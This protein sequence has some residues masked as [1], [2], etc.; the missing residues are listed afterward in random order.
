MPNV[1]LTEPMDY[2]QFTHAMGAAHLLLTDSGGVQEEAPSLGKP[3]LVMRDTTE[4]PEAVQAGTVRLVGTDEE[5]VAKRLDALLVDEDAYREM[6]MAHNPY[7]DG[8]AAARCAAAIGQLLA[9]APFAGF[10]LRWINEEVEMFENGIAVLGLGYIGLPTSAAIAMRGVLVKG[11]D[12]N[13]ATVEA[14]NRGEVPIVEPDLD[15]AVAGAHARGKLVAIH[16]RAGGGRLLDRR[17]DSLYRGQA[18]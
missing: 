14:V 10:P 8:V 16:G 18:A 9:W 12:V 11:V 3:V 7:G 15:V 6:A 17:A 5:V 4:R 1:L 2:H 13:L